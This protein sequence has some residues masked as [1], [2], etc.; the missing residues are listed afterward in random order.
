[1][2][3]SM[4]DRRR[5]PRKYLIIYSRVF[6]R[7]SGKLLGYL[8]D[9]SESGAMIISEETLEVGKTIALRFDLPDPKVF[10]MNSLHIEA[11]VTRCDSD[12]SPAFHDIGFE[13]RD[14]PP[15]K[16]KVIQQMM[17]IYEFQRFR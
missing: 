7:A 10:P 6:E 2:E 4:Q 17:K 11:A 12:L 16:L 14:V 1:M 9:L 8:S 5:L 3:A 13:F 15:E